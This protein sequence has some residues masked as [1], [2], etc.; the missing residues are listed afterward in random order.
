VACCEDNLGLFDHAR[1]DST[2]A[3]A[4]SKRR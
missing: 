4:I 1:N 2:F 3:L